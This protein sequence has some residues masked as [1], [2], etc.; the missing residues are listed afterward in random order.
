MEHLAKAYGRRI[1]TWALFYRRENNLPTRGSETNNYVETSMKLTKEKQ[2]SRVRTHNHVELLKVLC[3]DSALYV[4]K[5]VDIG[6]GR[7]SALRQAN[8]KYLER[9]NKYTKEQIVELGESRYFVQ[10]EKK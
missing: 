9:E 1:E 10:S 5:L 2:F 6:N 8:S 7:D 3:D 4:T